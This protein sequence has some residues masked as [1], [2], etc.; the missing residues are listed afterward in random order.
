MW[1]L[2]AKGLLWRLH[3]VSRTIVQLTRSN[4][5]HMHN[6]TWQIATQLSDLGLG[7]HLVDYHGLFYDERKSEK[8]F[9]MNFNSYKLQFHRKYSENVND[10][11]VAFNHGPPSWIWPG[12]SS[13]RWN[14]HEVSLLSRPAFCILPRRTSIRYNIYEKMADSLLKRIFSIKTFPWKLLQIL[15]PMWTL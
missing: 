11:K 8:T 5:K 2:A 1:L 10:E 3:L 13:I 9:G 6:N 4:P 12:R 14:I 15:V 7:G